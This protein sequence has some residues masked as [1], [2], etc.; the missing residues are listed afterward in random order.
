[1][2]I[3]NR[4]CRDGGFTLIELLVVIA[5]IALLI[6]IL[7]PG[8]GKARETG[9]SVKELSAISQLAKANATYSADFRDEIVP[10][11]IPKSWIWWQVC[12]K[13]MY[14]PDPNDRT[15]RITREAMRPW[16]WRLAGYAALPIPDVM[17]TNRNDYQLFRNRGDAGRTAEAGNLASYPD[18]SFVGAVATHPSFGMNTVF[19]GGDS[20]HAAFQKH[21]RTKCGFDS[22]L[23]GENPYGSGGMFYVDKSVDVRFPSEFITFA[24]ARAKDVS[25]TS[26]HDNGRTAADSP[27]LS[28]VRDG[29][30]KVM[31][32]AMV[33]SSDPDH[34]T[35]YL[36][37]VNGW[38]PSAPTTFVRG[39][40]PG[41]WGYLNPRY[42]GTTAA[43]RL[44]A[45]ARRMKIEELRN[46]RHWDNFADEN[47][48]RT[49][50]VYTF[51]PRR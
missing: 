36:P 47:T 27:L 21:G 34:G 32:P 25:G 50:G 9:R 16:T 46:M 17:V 2:R 35:S 3:R 48:N 1:M 12:D 41:T 45:S 20:N 37:L 51:R 43:T 11:R 13:S 19:F 40:S 8:L 38:Q 28:A 33:P 49:T 6:G 29:F 14:P 44:D 39:R 4:G 15:A 24:G 30:Y 23:G 10:G 5:V 26:Y 7:L 42:F 31:P 18:T 22:L